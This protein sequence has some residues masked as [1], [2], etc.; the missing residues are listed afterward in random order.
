MTKSIRVDDLAEEVMK[1]LYE[2]AD[3]TTDEVKSAVKEAT[4]TAKKEVEQN[5]PVRTGQYKKSWT[6]K[7]VSETAHTLHMVVHSK[8]YPLTHL[9][10]NGHATRA[11]GR[12]KAQ[13]HINPAQEHAGENVE[14]ILKR[15]L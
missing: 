4:K 11:G 14:R 3:F 12:T 8:K 2:Y 1:G 10:E 13:P 6:T 15:K 5:S 9:L 7:K